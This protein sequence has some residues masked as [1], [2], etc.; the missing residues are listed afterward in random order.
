M[1]F[2]LVKIPLLHQK[3][4]GL[5]WYQSLLST[6]MDRG[7]V[8]HLRLL[9]HYLTLLRWILIRCINCLIGKI[10]ALH[11]ARILILIYLELL[12]WIWYLS[13]GR[14]SQIL[15]RANFLVRRERNYCGSGE[16]G[17]GICFEILAKH[18]E[19]DFWT[20]VALISAHI[21][22][23]FFGYFSCLEPV[24]PMIHLL[25]LVALLVLVSLLLL[26]ILG[27]ARW[28]R[29]SLILLRLTN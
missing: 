23:G 26:E 18:S 13:R 24:I 12:T 25:L 8:V 3:I 17:V 29:A 14:I 19:S 2:D 6:V 27:P 9:E 16:R 5:R 4:L 7:K 11:F 10:K 20:R 15:P 21:L 1:C 28:A 22:Y